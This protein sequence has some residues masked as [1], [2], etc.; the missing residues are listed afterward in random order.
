MVDDSDFLFENWARWVKDRWFT[1]S[2]CKSL[3]SHYRSPQVWHPPEARP[4]EVVISDALE[5]ERVVS[6]LLRSENGSFKGYGELLK[7]HYVKR[8]RPSTTCR[9]ARIR[10]NEYDDCLSRAKMIVRNRMKL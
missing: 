3:E 8:A 1:P 7:G 9:I 4:P 10:M 5:V 2:M 6:W